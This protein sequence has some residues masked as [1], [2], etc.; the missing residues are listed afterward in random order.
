VAEN[1]EVK[2]KK[3]T[4]SKGEADQKRPQSKPKH[5]RRWLPGLTRF[6]LR[7]PVSKFSAELKTADFRQ[8][9]TSTRTQKM[10]ETP[11]GQRGSELKTINQTGREGETPRQ[12]K[13]RRAPVTGALRNF[14]KKPLPRKMVD[15][16]RERDPEQSPWG[17]EISPKTREKKQIPVT[18]TSRDLAQRNRE[19]S[20]RYPKQGEL[21]LDF[22]TTGKEGRG[23][24][25]SA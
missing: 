22:R 25:G 14:F 10:G 17:T 13:A 23:C 6:N 21:G 3:C 15:T 24:Y 20:G 19:W 4:D 7:S 8:A 18:R 9:G 12:T 5:E 2:K 1:V 11:S 16:K